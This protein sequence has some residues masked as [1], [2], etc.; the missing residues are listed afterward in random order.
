MEAL[1]EPAGAER[2]APL[3]RLHVTVFVYGEKYVTLFTQIV[4]PNLV[5]LIE[6]IP[7]DLR[8]GTRFRVLTDPPGS[9][10]IWASPTLALI[11][12]LVPVDISDKMEKAGYELYGG[13]GPMILGQARLV[14]E[15][16]L[17]NAG[18][19]FCPP[20][21]VWSKGSFAA[22]AR[23]ARNGAR[24]VI[25]PSARGIEE[26]LVP[27][28][29]QMIADSGTSRLNIT[30]K[31]LTG[32]L[33]THWQQ[34]NDGFIWNAPA[35]NVWKSYAYWRLD[36]QHF[37]MKCWQGP[38][39]FLWPFKEVKDYDGWI[40]HRLI[41]SCARRQSEVH[42]IRDSMTI[43]TLDLAPRGRGEG[44][45]LTPR[46]TWA[47]FKQLLNRKRH[48]RL[49]ILYGCYS[50]RI[51]QEPLPE[52]TWVE[53]ERAF[54]RETRPAMYAAIAIRPVLAILD[55]VYRHSGMAGLMLLLRRLL[56]L[57]PGVRGLVH[58]LRQAAFNPS[59]IFRVL[60]RF[61]L[62]VLRWPLKLFVR[63][64]QASGLRPRTR[65]L[66]LRDQLIRI[67]KRS[68]DKESPRW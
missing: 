26:E 42:V 43:Q 22:I 38:A 31:D 25:G 6:E 1:S 53:A 44:H 15:A 59:R 13:Y 8:R 64:V 62:T 55:G 24:A 45:N 16:S 37:L 17:A 56:R 49:N 33:Y 29:Q 46:K 58:E 51:Y 12:Q 68:R 52:A 63:A 14:H 2:S 34:M 47:L 65:L 21:L 35:S 11:H 28:F 9:A 67:F 36:A 27:I 57:I 54:D 41:K 48:C 5:G 23:S 10:A 18:I 39:L 50:V 4:L 30:S 3:E 32:L 60:I 20:D 40:D 19:I 61:F 7:A 66:R